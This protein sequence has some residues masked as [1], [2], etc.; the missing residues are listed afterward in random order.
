MKGKGREGE[1]LIM[2]TDLQGSRLEAWDT[3]V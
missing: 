2:D 1:K 3:Q